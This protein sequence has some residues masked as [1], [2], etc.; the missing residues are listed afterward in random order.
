MTTVEIGVPVTGRTR[1][2][3]YYYHFIL[4]LVADISQDANERNPKNAKPEKQRRKE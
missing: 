1:S 3:H 2:K 4:S